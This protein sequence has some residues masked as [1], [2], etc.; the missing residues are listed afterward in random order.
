M[1]FEALE[2]SHDTLEVLPVLRLHGGGGEVVPAVQDRLLAE[3]GEALPVGRHPGLGPRQHRAHG[4]A[5]ENKECMLLGNPFCTFLYTQLQFW[6]A[7]QFH[8]KIIK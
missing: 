3:R 7:V 1:S 5:T 2:G 4:A 8:T 6:S